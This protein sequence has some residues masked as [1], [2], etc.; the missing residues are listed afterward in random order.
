[1]ASP[2]V[3]LT[4]AGFDPSSGA[5]ITADI[6]TI[7]AHGCY[8]VAAITAVTAQSTMAVGR[9]MS[10]PA[11][12]VRQTLEELAADL[13]FAAVR[14]GMLGTGQIAEVV[15]EFLEHG[16][17]PN[18]V[19]DPILRSSSGAVLLDPA[20]VEV[21]RTRLLPLAAVITPNLDEASV[22]TAT[23]VRTPAQMEAAAGRLHQL[24]A[25]AVVVKG[26][27]LE[28]DET[29]DLL[30]EAPT[31]SCREF[32]GPRLHSRATHG[33]GCAFATALAC[34][35]ALGRPLPEAVGAAKQFVATAIARAYPLG[36]GL[37]PLHH[38]FKLDEQ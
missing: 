21:L 16:Q 37:G 23:E 18:V 5:G 27:H 33:T 15:A 31:M 26:G 11:A 10:L 22:L 20:G 13:T 19:L 2:P 8:G 29:L 30:S 24:G 9:V 14:I 1:M 38:L 35:L 12:L 28:A 34:N 3:V 4:I 32:R 36:H 25:K 6:K 17:V 7:A